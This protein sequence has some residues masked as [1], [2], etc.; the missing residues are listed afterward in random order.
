MA[1]SSDFDPTSQLQNN[2]PS[3][4]N[5]PAPAAKLYNKPH[6]FQVYF[7]KKKS[8]SKKRLDFSSITLWREDRC[9]ISGAVHADN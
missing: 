2:I 1:T 9:S 4:R 5:N 7:E 8:K 6:L 3:W